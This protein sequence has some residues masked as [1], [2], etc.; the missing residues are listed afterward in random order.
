[1]VFLYPVNR[2]CRRKCHPDDSRRGMASAIQR[3]SCELP[4]G[5]C[6]LV[7]SYLLRLERILGFIGLH[8]LM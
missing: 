7:N 5:M 4:A 6:A 2:E 3:V 1:M 8:Y